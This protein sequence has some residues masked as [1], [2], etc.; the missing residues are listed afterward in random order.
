MPIAYTAVSKPTHAIGIIVRKIADKA[1][2]VIYIDPENNSIV[3]GLVEVV[4]KALPIGSSVTFKQRLVKEQTYSNNCGPELIENIAHELTDF[5]VPE[6][7]V[8][9]FHSLL[10]EESLL[11]V[12]EVSHNSTS[13]NTN[14]NTESTSPKIP[15]LKLKAV[16][17]PELIVARESKADPFYASFINL[18]SSI[19]KVP[20][21]FLDAWNWGGKIMSQIQNMVEETLPEL[22][23]DE[24]TARLSFLFELLDY[25]G[26]N[27]FTPFPYFPHKPDDPDDWGGNGDDKKP[28][29]DFGFGGIFSSGADNSNS[30][31]STTFINTTYAILVGNYNASHE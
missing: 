9:E 16:E 28:E 18:V 17:T 27:H 5:R 3:P 7:L 31:N 12:S 6:A 13:T 1:Y 22:Q 8:P 2:Q 30:T 11:K 14:P 19:A 10:L 20:A 23:T 24:Q 25:V 21:V 26:S 29:D 15:V 4:H